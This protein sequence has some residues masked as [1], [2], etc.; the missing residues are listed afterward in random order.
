LPAWRNRKAGDISRREVKALIQGI[1]E[2]GAGVMANRTLAL[3]SKIFNFAVEEEVVSVNPAYRVPKATKEQSRSRVLTEDEIKA[4]WLALDGQ[5]PRVAAI[6]RLLLMTGQ[7]KSEI[8]GMRW[9]ELDLERGWW[10]IPEERSK[11]GVVY[12]VPL[13]PQALEILQSL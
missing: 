1:A 5:R 9:Q 12:R 2:R 6:F 11:N 4:V 3:I 7:R 8:T 13:T 10:T